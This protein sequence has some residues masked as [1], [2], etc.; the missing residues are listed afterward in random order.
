MTYETYLMH[1]GVK[2]QKWGVKHGPPYPLQSGIRTKIKKVT[3]AAKDRVAANR[4]ARS[5]RKEAKESRRRAK[6]PTLQDKISMMSDEELRQRTERLRLENAYKR[7]LPR[8][9]EGESFLRKSASMLNSLKTLGDAV[10]GLVNT[11]KSLGKAFGL[12]KLEGDDENPVRRDGESLK[13]YAQ[14]MAQ[15]ASLKKS[16]D[17]L[18]VSSNKSSDDSSSEPVKPT[19]TAKT[20]KK[21]PFFAFDKDSDNSSKGEDSTLSAFRE[22]AKK[23]NVDL[24]KPVE[25][26]WDY[27]DTGKSWFKEAFPKAVPSSFSDWTKDDDDKKKKGG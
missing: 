20:P 7:E 24:D 17:T 23:W 19:S 1:H 4:K 11:G 12:D 9:Q 26:V 21:G 3:Q 25:K 16:K 13:D 2:G 18:G 15:L 10:S 27:S 5:E 22:E 14:R 8:E 6:N